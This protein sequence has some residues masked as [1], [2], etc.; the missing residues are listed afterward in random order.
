MARSGPAVGGTNQLQPIPTEVRADRARRGTEVHTM[1]TLVGDV[2]CHRPTG[3][4]TPHST[5][6]KCFQVS[7]A[8]EQLQMAMWA[9]SAAPLF[10]SND[11]KAIP[12]ASAAILLNAG[13]LV[14]CSACLLVAR[15]LFF[16]GLFFC[17]CVC[18][19]LLMFC[20]HAG[21]GHLPSSTLPLDN[22]VPATTCEGHQQRSS[23]PNA[24]PVCNR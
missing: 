17:F 23:G 5:G 21:R 11:V 16:F 14:R 18:W 13:V 3:R 15:F 9:L 12:P 10:M 2:A 1:L 7:H 24:L 6:M 22:T 4:Y 19:S 20:A 8:E